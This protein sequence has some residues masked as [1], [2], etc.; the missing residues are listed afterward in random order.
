MVP[1]WSRDGA[2][3][4]FGSNRSG[5]WHVWK[6]ASGGGTATPVT[7]GG[8]FLAMAAPTEDHPMLYYTH[9]DKP[10]LFRMPR[11]GGLEELV[12][13]DLY[14]DDWGNWI[15]TEVGI[16]F[17]QR[18]PTRL[19]FFDYATGRI[20]ELGPLQHVPT[21]MVGLTLSPDQ[22]TLAFVQQRYDNADLWMID[23]FE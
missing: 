20:T 14:H 5:T 12:L 13:P 9:I 6:I 1:S 3:I 8:G 18:R 23:D 17:L 21:G 11:E 4:Y 22:K 19:A 16:Y 10:G 15:A 7:K 2:S